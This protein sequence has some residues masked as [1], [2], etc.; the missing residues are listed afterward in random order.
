MMENK[1]KVSYYADNFVKI[2]KLSYIGNEV[3][4]VFILPKKRFGLSKVLK[5]LTGEKL[6]NYIS[7]ATIKDVVVSHL[8]NFC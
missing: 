6:S 8:F 2:I 5:Y 7:N 4:M 3:E 1:C